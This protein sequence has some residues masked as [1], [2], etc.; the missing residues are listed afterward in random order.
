MQRNP[1]F[2]TTKAQMLNPRFILHI[3]I[4]N[5]KKVF[6][7]TIKWRTDGKT[8]QEKRQGNFH[9]KLATANL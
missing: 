6:K 9:A 2:R 3:I 4:D 1:K 7:S 8:L 5:K